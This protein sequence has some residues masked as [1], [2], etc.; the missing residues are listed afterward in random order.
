MAKELSVLQ[1]QAEAIKNEVNKGANTA[2]RVGSMFSDML[3]YNEEQSV[4]DKANTGISTFPVFSEVTAYTV[5]QVVNYNDKLYKFTAD[6][7]AGAW[8]S[9][10]VAPT[11]LKEIQDEKLTEL[12]SKTDKVYYHSVYLD[13]NINSE[14]KKKVNRAIKELW[15][16]E[17][18]QAESDTI[19][20]GNVRRNA[21]STSGEGQWNVVLYDYSKQ[22]T[23]AFESF[24]SINKKGSLELL[25]GKNGSYCLI[26][27][28]EIEDGVQLIGSVSEGYAINKPY[29]SDINNFPIIKSYL[30]IQKSNADVNNLFEIVSDIEP[31][32]YKNLY[33]SIYTGSNSNI[34][35]AN[36]AIKELW[37]CEY[38]ASV[39]TV[40][41]GL[42][43]KN[44]G[45]S[46]QWVIALYDNSNQEEIITIESF[47]SNNN[48][49]TNENAGIELIKGKKGS[50]ILIDWSEYEDGSWINSRSTEYQLNI[51]YVS[52]VNN[53]PIIK[54]KIRG[55]TNKIY[56]HSL[57][58]NENE[59][60]S[61]IN[62]AVKELWLNTSVIDTESI[63]FGNIRK[64]FTTTS[65]T[66]WSIWLY[67]SSKENFEI[68]ESFTSVNKTNSL[69]IIKGTNGSY[70]LVDW[71]EIEEGNM[72]VSNDIIYNLNIP[73]V[74][75]IN[76]FPIIQLSTKQAIVSLEY[77]YIKRYNVAAISWVDDDFNLTSVPKIKAICD[78]VGCKIDFGLVP[79][80]TKGTGDYPTD[81][82]Y[83]FTEEQLELIKQYELEGFHMQIHPVHRGW[84][85]SASAG[86]YQGRSWTEQS[87]VKTIRLFKE[88]NILN[89]SCIIYPGSSPTFQD[90]VDMVKTWLEFGV[91]AGGKYNMGICNKY[92]LARY[93]VNISSSQTK[94]QIKTVIDEAVKNGAW[95]ILGTHGHQF[96]DSGTID[97]TTPSLANLQEIIDYANSKIP[98]KPIGE[99][100]RKR[101]PMLD[102]FVV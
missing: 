53:F 32:A 43:R 31:K 55:I 65:S 98:I 81:S 44:H 79:T 28:S 33:H 96:N 74:S 24:T 19:C 61:K 38:T 50:Y 59:M 89:D 99:V 47:V 63:C 23:E 58:I 9:A 29:I 3:D 67:D 11:S 83:S 97:E 56:Y 102:L 10:H 70:I 88:N 54:Q 15:L 57:F 6:H 35:K 86:T 91:M 78:E 21:T 40:S 20:L 2:N 16:S 25:K 13:D 42:I 18:K 73:Y 1:Q 62:K 100:F 85:E 84:Y 72:L 27:W 4:T 77:E 22:G 82:V 41:L 90:T 39:N 48:A 68:V 45:E 94:T 87:L 52:D 30:D 37:L 34:I 7:P 17:E 5:D 92:K 95:L 101:K 75:D 80:Y 71:S 36:K 66:Y 64:N 69:E 14:N 46:H 26:D 60:I 49:Q 8:N 76:N 93:F 12:E 51:P